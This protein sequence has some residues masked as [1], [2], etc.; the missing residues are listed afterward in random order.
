VNRIYN[1]EAKEP[2]FLNEKM[3]REK[4]KRRKTRIM[5]VL[6]ACAGFLSQLCILIIGLITLENFPI[7]SFFCFL[8]LVVALSGG[9]AVLIV[10]NR[11]RSKFV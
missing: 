3:L 8:Y 5:S 4:M 9:C 6:L 11:E 1:F 2:P 7:L 10:F